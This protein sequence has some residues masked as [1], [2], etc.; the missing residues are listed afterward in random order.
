MTSSDRTKAAAKADGDL[1]YEVRDGIGLITFNRPAARNALTFGM[2]DR[3]AEICA[4]SPA[5]GPVKAIVLTGAGGRAFAAGTD[6]SLFRDFRSAEQGLEYEKRAEEIFTAIE[7]CPVPTIAAIAGACTGGG[8]AIAACCDIRIAARD[9][10]FGFPIARTLGNCLSAATLAR[11]VA[12]LGEARVV[13]LIYTARLM[14]AEEARSIGLVSEL[15]DSP[16]AVVARAMSLAREI[17]GH[18][19]LTLRITKE[20]LRRLRARSPKVDD[21]DLIAKAYTSADFREGLEA[22]LAKRTPK[23]SGK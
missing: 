12:L 15:I 20:L 10:K 21:R 1:L 19:P 22:F 7:S 4:N 9:L 18:A 13:D 8:A 3:L 11:L 16:A 5:D 23:W 14:D 17:A 2:Y 6:I